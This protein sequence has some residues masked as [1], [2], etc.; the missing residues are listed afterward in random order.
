MNDSDVVAVRGI[1][2]ARADRF[3]RPEPVPYLGGAEPGGQPVTAPQLPGRLERVM[4]APVPLP[5]SEDCLELSVT[6]PATTPDAA[7]RPVLVWIHGGAYLAGGGAWNLYDPTELVRETG[8]VVVSINYRLGVLGYLRMP[9][10]APGNLGLLDQIAALTWVREHIGEFGGDPARV[11]VAGQSAGAHSI[12]AMLGIE[13]TRGLFRRAIVQSAPFGIGFQSARKAERAAQRF[14]AA[15]RSDP[16]EASTADILAAQG[17]AV[18]ASAGPGGLNSAP[19]F[20][21]IADVDPLPDESR[22]RR[23]VVRRAGELQVLIGTTA[24]EMG[25]F[26]GGPHPVFSR[27]RRFPFGPRIASGVQQ[28]VG[29]KAFEDGTTAF[30]DLLAAHDAEVYRYRVRELHPGNPFGPCHCLD[31]PLLFGDDNAWRDAAMVR[32]LSRADLR[33]LG[34]RTRS[35]WG[36]FVHTGD[37][38]WQRSLPGAASIHPIP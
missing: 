21:P 10:V 33:A 38:G 15:L 37:P 17:A 16:R 19:P 24:D 29:R 13:S 32:P 26:Y 5:Q 14:H 4:G 7:G 34:S 3:G 28:L 6:A 27:I 9:G 36:A 35:R 23:E 31:L 20:A 18:R 8:I 2:F 11:T 1:R 30:A 25:A 22:W 12:V